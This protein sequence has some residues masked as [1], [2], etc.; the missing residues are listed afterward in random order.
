[1]RNEKHRTWALCAL[2]AL[3]VVLVFGRT[4]WHDFV[5]FDDDAYVY[6]NPRVTAGLTGQ[7]AAWAFTAFHANN[8]HPLT[9]LSH[10]LDCQWYGS[11]LAAGHHLTNVVLHAAAVIVLFL[12]LR[13]M[14]GR[15]WP[16]ALAAAMFAVHPLRVE[17]V[18]WV[19]ERKDLLSG[20]FFLLALAAYL[21]YARRPFA[22]GRYLLLMATF[23][24]GLMAKPMVV[25]LPIVLLLL[26][27]WPLSRL[28]DVAARRRVVLE[29][30]PLLALSAASCV[31]TSLAQRH[32]VVPLDVVPLGPRIA[33]ALISCVAYVGQLC[34]PAGLAT[35]YPLPES[36]APWWKAVAALFVLVGV[37]VAA[38]LARRRCPYL[39]VGWAWYLVMLMPVIGV[40]QVGAQAMAD[41][42]TY[43][44]EIGLGIAMAWG[45]ADVAARQPVRRWAFGAL[46]GAVV[47]AWMLVAWRQTAYWRNGETLWTRTLACT[48]QNVFAHNNLGIMLAQHGDIEGAIR[49][50]RLAMAINPDSPIPHNNL[51]NALVA[52]GR[53]DEAVAAFCKVL[54]LSPEYAS[55][56]MNL[57]IALACRG[58]IEA[59]V[60]E[61]RRAIA[62]DPTN[63]NAH[64]NLGIFLCRCGRFDAAVGEFRA[65][66]AI[67]PDHAGAHGNLGA[68]LAQQGN[69]AE[70]MRHWNAAVKADPGNVRNFNQ[71]AWASATSADAKLRNAPAAVALAQWAARLSRHREPDVLNTLAAAYA[72]AGRFTEAV[73]TARKAMT[74]AAEQKQPA[75]AESIQTKLAL[76]EAGTPFRESPVDRSKK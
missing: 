12:V 45:L 15:F 20:L 62:L 25:T 73:E 70:A 4:C 28:E 19:S 5:N 6:D 13:S 43:L 56:H 76:Y 69:M 60:G 44:P 8:W 24:L 10:Q 68:A 72:A 7:S 11:R 27:Y 63:A 38:W 65:A 2:L 30:L 37:S 35:F 32:A 55:A 49:Q 14:T 52:C 1:M 47:L 39:L 9:W 16:C 54:A 53:F 41:R 51:G 46:A 23:A 71:L 75:L 64:N 3:A 74:I 50:Y 58:H 17:S 42:Y 18:A 57:S 67:K 26:D 40:V 36:G 48:S 31:V 33:N 29:K 61:C 59:A 22:W 21:G 66:L 34:Y